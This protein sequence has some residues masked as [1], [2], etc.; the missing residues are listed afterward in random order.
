MGAAPEALVTVN[1]KHTARV[2][3]VTGETGGGSDAAA[4]NVSGKTTA[5]G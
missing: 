1:Q 4:V 3:A 2:Y 5:P